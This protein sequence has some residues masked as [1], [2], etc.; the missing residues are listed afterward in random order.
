ML[1]LSKIQMNATLAI[2]ALRIL[3]FRT[4]SGSVI[5]PD[6]H[7]NA[8]AL[9]TEMLLNRLCVSCMINLELYME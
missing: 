2:G 1:P 7:G 9:A 4:I 6:A 3:A 5:E 8:S